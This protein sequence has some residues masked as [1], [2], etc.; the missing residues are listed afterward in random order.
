[1]CIDKN[2]LAGRISCKIIENKEI[3][4][5]VFEM[6]IEGN[7]T[8]KIKPG[9]FLNLYCKSEA[10][11]LP[12][13]I[14]ICEVIEKED[15]VRLIYGIVGQGTKIFSGYKKGD[16]I[17]ALGPLGNGFMTPECEESIIVGGGLGTPPL[18][19]LV[20]NIKG[21]K[22]I[23][24]GFR[25]NPYLV[26][27]FKKYGEVFLATDD[28]KSGYKGTVI[29]LLNN[30]KANGQIIYACGP[31]P[32]LKALKEWSN[33][34][35]IPGWFSLEERMGCGFG[36]CVGCVC[37]IEENNEFGFTYKKVCKDGPVFNAKE[38]LF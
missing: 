11:M 35:N 3:A 24:L 20:K 14:S 15:C 13:P 29:D 36:A 32:M 1:M 16:R 4:N 17:D 5:E 8:D 25:T 7:F 18:L 12:R 6:L 31:V 2:K 22:T 38:V 30:N 19:E 37:K 23:Y 10:L 28:G 34:H 33:K 9:Q 27:D 26:D 21:K